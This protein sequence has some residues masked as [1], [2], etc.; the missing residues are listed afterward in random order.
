MTVL[1]TPGLRF[2]LAETIDIRATM[3]LLDRGLQENHFEL[4]QQWKDDLTK[5][6]EARDDRFKMLN[7][8]L[9]S[10]LFADLPRLR[11]HLKAQVFEHLRTTHRWSG[12]TFMLYDAPISPQG[13]CD[14]L[15]T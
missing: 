2:E 7:D 15:S 12:D 14:Q 1:R 4:R 11:E 13:T 5:M 3:M 10:C 8:H 6:A 9:R